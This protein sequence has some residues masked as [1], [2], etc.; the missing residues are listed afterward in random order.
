EK[1][2][3]GTHPQTPLVVKLQG[4]CYYGDGN[5]K[6]WPEILPIRF[7]GNETHRQVTI[8]HNR[9]RDDNRDDRVVESA[10]SFSA[11]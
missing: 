6:P 8:E 4:G 1:L 5:G 11:P 3:T 10:L 7:W 9:T 2:T